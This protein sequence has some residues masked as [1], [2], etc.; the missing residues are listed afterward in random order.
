M[1][2]WG[3]GSGLQ[4]LGLGVRLRYGI[5][6]E[7]APYVGASWV[8]QFGETA[9]FTEAAGEPVSDLSVVGGVRFWL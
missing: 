2:E 7:L 3:V 1:P 4:G 9:R 6:R 5:R 8:R